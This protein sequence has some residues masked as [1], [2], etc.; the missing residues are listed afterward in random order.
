MK[1]LSFP[2]KIALLSLAASFAGAPLIHAQLSLQP[3]QQQQQQS[4]DD[5]EVPLNAVVAVVNEDVITM[6]E[7]REL[8]GS[9]E[10]ALQ[11]QYAQQPDQLRQQIL[12]LRSEAVK[13]LI[14]RQLILQ[15]FKKMEAKGASIPDFVVEDHIRT[16]IRGQF[17]GDRAAFIRTLDAQGMTLAKYR[18]MERDKIIV[19]AMRERELKKDLFIPPR[20]VQEYYAQ[21]ISEFSIPETIHLRMIS[22][23]KGGATDA[24][25]RKLAQEIQQKVAAGAEFANLAQLYSETHATDGGDYGWITHGDINDELGK[26]AFSLKPGKVSN[27]VD[28]SGSYWL[29]YV[30][31]RKAGGSRSF[32]EVRDDIQKKLLQVQEQEEQEKWLAGLRQKAYIKTF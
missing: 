20:D 2:G 29:L 10:E 13:E 3:Q 24:T 28:S 22:L 31:A 27:I 5:T 14:D 30:E 21:H 11:K 7:V 4:N 19:S 9:Q 15:E 32:N 17:N 12:D 16:I 1:N 18:E 26:V 6:D 25:Q 8:T 23:T